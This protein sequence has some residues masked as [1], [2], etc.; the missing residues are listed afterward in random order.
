MQVVDLKYTIMR[1]RYILLFFIFPFIGNAQTRLILNHD[2]YLNLDNGAKIVLDNDNSNAITEINGGGMVISESEDNEFIWHVKEQSGQTYTVPFGTKPALLGGNGTKIPVSIEISTGGTQNT[3]GNISFATWETA[4]DDNSSLPTGVTN[5][6]DRLFAVDR[7]WEVIPSDYNVT[8]AVNLSFT[9]DDDFQNEIGNVLNEASLVAQNYNTDTDNWLSTSGAVNVTNNVVSGVSLN[10]SQFSS[11]SGL[12]TMVD[13]AMPL[14]ITLL[15]FGAYC[16]DRNTLLRW[17]TATEQNNDYF[18]MEMS[19]DIVNFTEIGRLDGAGNSNELKAY[20]LLVEKESRHTTY[21]R[22]KQVDFNG[23]FSYSN[24]VAIS[25][26]AQSVSVEV[27]PNPFV[28]DVYIR[29]SEEKNVEYTIELI[30]G[31]GRVVSEEKV[32][33]VAAAHKLV[34]G[35]V[36]RPGLYTIK[37]KDE[38]KGVLLTQKLIKI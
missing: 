1:K 16:Q 15:S 12:W 22:L 25:P 3:S 8:P 6:D 7:F 35:G 18:V 14:P 5:A 30:D 23:D 28:E 34:V 29:F 38:L 17:E 33:G 13:A 20:S 27:Y 37:I 19:H 26:C 36:N 10:S 2:V 11:F 32:D 21:Y 9:Y 24:L 4:T 31:Y